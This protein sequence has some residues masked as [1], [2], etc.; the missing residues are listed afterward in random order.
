MLQSSPRFRPS[1]I[2][3]ER[4]QVPISIHARTG[5]DAG[6]KPNPN[7]RPSFPRNPDST[8]SWP[9]HR[10]ATSSG[11]P[12]PWTPASAAV[13]TVGARRS[14]TSSAA[15]SSIRS[16]VSPADRHGASDSP[17][18]IDGRGPVQDARRIAVE[19]IEAEAEIRRDRP[20]KRCV[21]GTTTGSRHPG[22]GD[23]RID[24]LPAYRRRT[25]DMQ[26][27][28]DLHF[29]QLAEMRVE[30]AKRPVGIARD[31]CR[32]HDRGRAVPRRRRS[33]ARVW[34]AAAGRPRPRDNTRRSASRVRRA[35]RGSRRESSAASGDR[36]SPPT[37]G[38][39]PG[40]PRPDR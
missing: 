31:E 20:V 24:P 38:A 35:A 33:R 8:T 36:R 18:S 37:R 10:P 27:I 2:D 22:D 1:R 30:S 29:L 16:T 6:P 40:C 39:W 13:T 28:A 5:A 17:A 12:V 15:S 21:G 9:A 3:R 32:G 23:Q 4:E 26:T 34:R 7:P 14:R 19:R 11:V 25:E